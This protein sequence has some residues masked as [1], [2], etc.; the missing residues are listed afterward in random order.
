M[1]AILTYHSIDESGSPISLPERVFREQVTWLAR[2]GV[3]VV[4]LDGLMRLPVDAD[5]VALTFD[6]GFVNFSDIAAPLLSE[7]GLPATLFIVSDA[8]GRTNRWPAGADQGVP[9]L[10]LL[11]W[12]VLGRLAE[13]GVELGAHSRTHVDLAR[14]SEARLSDEIVGGAERIRRETGHAPSVFAYPYGSVTAGA[15]DVVAASFAWGCTTDMRAVAA[16]EPPARLPRID[17]YYLRGR[18]ELERWGSPRF[19]YQL[20]LRAGARRVR[21]RLRSL[22]GAA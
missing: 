7:H 2:G 4:T 3:P 21:R 16:T 12:D 14:V 5:A 19:R 11:G 9:E 6:D 13:Q 15:A 10:P 22:T 1:R 20:R 18:G 17:M 8:A